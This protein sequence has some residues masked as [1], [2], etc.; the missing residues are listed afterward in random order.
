MFDLV[1]ANLKARPFRT[2][3]S[4]I[5]VALSVVL[6]LLFSGLAVGV[7]NDMARR[8]ANWKAE[9][10]FTRP[11]AM[12]LTSSSPSLST[13]YVRE[14]IKIDGVQSVVPVIRYLSPNPR[15]KWG[16][17][18]IDGVDW[19]PFA[20]MNQMR[21]VEGRAP[22]ANDEVIL[23]EREMRGENRKIGD[24]INL[25]GGKPYR[26]V[27]VFSPPSGARIK[28]SLSAMQEVLEAPNKCTYILVK[29]KDGEDAE[30]VAARI[31]EALPGNKI[32]LTRDLLI[33][34]QDR[35]PGLNK[36]LQVLV[37]LGAFASS[38]FV[39]LSMY[40]TV[41]ERRY[42]IGVLKALGASKSFIISAI[43]SEAL[44]VGIAGV[45]LGLLV[46]LLASIFI[47]KKFELAV[48]FSLG[49]V[50]T[51]IVIAAAGSLIGAFYPAWKASRIDPVEVMMNE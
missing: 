11:G 32:N 46:S 50:M 45:L 37:G 40:T 7:S 49:W 4:I 30:K 51:A 1:L 36:F 44:F 38:I 6:V 17:Q 25:F 24:T 8:A 9:I 35:V 16:F 39:L 47:Q 13:G 18:Q 19:E 41:T 21:I 29:I 33:D 28:M 34:A 5:G 23:D 42:E 26:I 22:M 3:I 20:K 15:G 43:E 31:N 10:V 2:A 14:L 27:G 48:E 12:E